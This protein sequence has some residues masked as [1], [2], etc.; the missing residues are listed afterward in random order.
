MPLLDNEGY[1]K[2]QKNNT[3][4]ESTVT[5]T[6]FAMA[7][8]TASATAIAFNGNGILPENCPYFF[9]PI[10]MRFNLSLFSAAIATKKT[11]NVR[12]VLNPKGHA[13]AAF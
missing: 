9:R 4:A 3:P 6:L 13:K 1:N 5:V 8:A 12:H 11:L 2:M 7:M 10:R